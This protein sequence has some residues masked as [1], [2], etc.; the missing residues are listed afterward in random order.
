MLFAAILDSGAV[1]AHEPEPRTPPQAETGNCVGALPIVVASDTAAQS[2]MYSA[3]TLAGALGTECIILAGE[4]DEPFP[5][6][7]LEC[8]D[9]AAPGGYVVGGK[10]AVPDHKLSDRKVTRISGAD[11]WETARAVGAEVQRVLATLDDT[12][13]KRNAG[14]GTGTAGNRGC[15]DAA[16]QPDRTPAVPV[17]EIES[18]MTWRQLI[19][20]IAAKSET[21]CIDDALGDELPDDLLDDML[22]F[23][24]FAPVGWPTVGPESSGRGADDERWPHEMWRCMAPETATAVYLSAYIR[25]EG[26]LTGI[27]GPA[28]TDCISGLAHHQDLSETAARVLTREAA[29]DDIELAEFLGELDERTTDLV[30][31]CFP[32]L[33]EAGIAIAISDI[34]ESLFEY[35]LSQQELDCMVDA[36][37]EEARRTDFDFSAALEDDLDDD[38]EEQFINVIFAG[39]DTCVSADNQ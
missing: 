31:W 17:L 8:L 34:Y 26:L 7:E 37:F 27:Y 22:D 16:D 32:Q 4:R 30:V 39:A 36:A 29:L 10:T 19:E 9:A 3:V 15:G 25:T 33:A 14:T 35:T 23:T 5:A 24:L 20:A 11:R 1:A 21:A 18:D 6:T 12:A 2:D 38:F 13:R 28:D